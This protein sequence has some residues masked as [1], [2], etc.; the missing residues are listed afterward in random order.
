MSAMQLTSKSP[1]T[2]QSMA[3]AVG[4]VMSKQQGGRRVS[5]AL[6]GRIE[7]GGRRGARTGKRGNERVHECVELGWFPTHSRCEGNFTQLEVHPRIA[8][9]EVPV[10]RFSVLQLNK[11]R[12]V[13]RLPQQSE[14]KHGSCP[15][16][17]TYPTHQSPNLETA[18]P[19][20]MITMSTVSD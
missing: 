7:R 16:P 2:H 18:W 20:Q 6:T 4:H 15:L 3:R 12:S 10:V 5:I 8:R 11:H 1:P 9:L 19:P 17:L 14:R 13:L